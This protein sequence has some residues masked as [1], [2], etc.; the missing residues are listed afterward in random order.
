M[1]AKAISIYKFTI[2]A[3]VIY[4]LVSSSFLLSTNL[5]LQKSAKPDQSSFF[6]PRADKLLANSA[7]SEFILLQNPNQE[8]D[9]FI[10]A[11]KEGTKT[12]SNI[13]VNNDPIG[14]LIKIDL[15]IDNVSTGFWGWSLPSISWN[16][17]VLNLT[18]VQEGAFLAN[19]TGT[20]AYFIG[21]SPALWNNT[22]GKIDGGLT[23][24]LSTDST[25]HD[26][27]GALATLTFEI[28]S[29]GTS[30]LTLSGA[31]TVASINQA[32][33]KLYPPNYLPCYNATIK[34]LSTN[35]SHL[36]LLSWLIAPLVIIPL[37]CVLVYAWKKKMQG[38]SPGSNL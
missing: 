8:S 38:H 23:E 3:L 32:D 19:Q 12:N 11:V 15:R 34:V 26:S 14:S 37:I 25:S 13:T 36:N 4:V 16:P 31:F 33:T 28:K 21:N 27:S 10:T 1:E 9:P 35:S 22:S 30:L 20:S 6:Y 17:A 2:I 29:N 7:S 24:A 18:D 5:N